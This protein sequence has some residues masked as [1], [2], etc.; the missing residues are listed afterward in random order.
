VCIML[1]LVRKFDNQVCLATLP[2]NLGEVRVVD[3]SFF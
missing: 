2:L 3:R 1:L